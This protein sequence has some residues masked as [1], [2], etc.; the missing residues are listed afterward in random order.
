M[1]ALFCNRVYYQKLIVWSSL[2][3]LI[4]CTHTISLLLKGSC[5]NAM[6]KVKPGYYISGRNN[7]IIDGITETACIQRCFSETS[8]T[9]K[10][11]DY[12]AILG[13]NTVNRCTLSTATEAD[14]S[15]ITSSYF[16]ASSYHERLCN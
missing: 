8:F 14:A 6:A 2:E 1:K 12:H 11:I 13:S 4:Y 3:C 9:C 15:L 5:L 10:S 7:L 16:P